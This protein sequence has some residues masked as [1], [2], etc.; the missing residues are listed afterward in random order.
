MTLKMFFLIFLG[1]HLSVLWPQNSVRVTNNPERGFR[2]ETLYADV[3]SIE[4]DTHNQAYLIQQIEE[5]QIQTQAQ[6]KSTSAFL[7]G[8]FCFF[9][10]LLIYI[11][12]EQYK[13]K[14]HTRLTEIQ[15]KNLLAETEHQNQI[16]QQHIQMLGELYKNINARLNFI[17]TSI[18]KLHF[19]TKDK[20]SVASEKISEINT[21]T[22]NAITQF[23]DTIWAMR[24]LI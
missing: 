22:Q 17:A 15:L 6:Q 20:H 4:R 16:Q 24:N 9:S 23:R 14:K 7:V 5:T 11:V 10:L 12:R 19:S 2:E 18:D 13:Q 1:L 21:F 3:M 8:L